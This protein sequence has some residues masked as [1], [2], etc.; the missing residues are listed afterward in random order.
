MLSLQLDEVKLA[1]MYTP[2]KDIPIVADNKEIAGTK[3][4]TTNTTV[5]K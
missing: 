5:T 3:S 4:S 1:E 2:I